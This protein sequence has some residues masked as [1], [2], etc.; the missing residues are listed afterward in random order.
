MSPFPQRVHPRLPL[1]PC[2]I[3]YVYF[4]S[5]CVSEVRWS[6]TRHELAQRATATEGRVTEWKTRRSNKGIISPSG[7]HL[8]CPRF[9]FLPRH[10]FRSFSI[11]PGLI[12]WAAYCLIGHLFC[13]PWSVFP[14]ISL[15]PS[16]FCLI[17]PVFLLSLIYPSHMALPHLAWFTCSPLFIFL[18]TPKSSQILQYFFRCLISNIIKDRISRLTFLNS[19]DL[20][21]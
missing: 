9:L 8:C 7:W 3:S 15:L 16:G 11:F 17:P 12:R 1:S 13:F 14:S 19:S 2:L 21:I 10:V 18:L 5:F 6:D 4:F 20:T